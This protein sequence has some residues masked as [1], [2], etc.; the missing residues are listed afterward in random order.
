V[1]DAAG[2]EVPPGWTA[3]DLRDPFEAL[4]GPLYERRHADGRD[5]A[6]RVAPQ[7]TNARG[8]AHGG[9]IMTFCDASLG[10]AASDACGGGSIATVTMNVDFVGPARVGDWVVARMRVTR[11]TRTMIFVTG[12][13]EVPSAD[14]GAAA[15]VAT[16]SSVFKILGT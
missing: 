9:M 6:F 1:T 16:A 12:T 11:R 5:M 14:G 13:L 3:Q 8:I 4:A 2:A 7:H 15:A 10:A